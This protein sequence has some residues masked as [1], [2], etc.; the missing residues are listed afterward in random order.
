MSTIYSHPNSWYHNWTLRSTTLVSLN[1]SCASFVIFDRHITLPNLCLVSF[2]ELWH[3]THAQVASDSRRRQHWA[4]WTGGGGEDKLSWS[5]DHVTSI[6]M[7]LHSLRTRFVRA[8]TAVYDVQSVE[9]R[10]GSFS[11]VRLSDV[12]LTSQLYSVRRTFPS[13]PTPHPFHVT[14]SCISH[15]MLLVFDTHGSRNC[16]HS[17]KRQFA[18]VL[19]CVSEVRFV[20]KRDVSLPWTPSLVLS[21]ELLY[22]THNFTL[23]Q[24]DRSK[25]LDCTEDESSGLGG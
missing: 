25:D 7:P 11:S 10:Y 17:G 24:V 13:P 22:S 4:C 16:G 6:K 1:T 15:S 9:K 3:L 12:N 20:F 8:G 18:V 23:C 14:T 2:G 21:S 19:L 5:D